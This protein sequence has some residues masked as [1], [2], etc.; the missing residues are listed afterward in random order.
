MRRGL[1]L[2]LGLVLS[3]MAG[4]AHADSTKPTLVEVWH[5]GD[6]SLS[7]GLFLTVENAFKHSPE[8]TLSSGLKTGTL[9]V[10]IPTHVEWRRVGQR[11][12]VLYKV[13]FSSTEGRNLS[14]RKGTC[15]DNEM[16]KC[17]AHIVND[18]KV[19]VHKLDQGQDGK[20][21]FGLSGAVACRPA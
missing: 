2:V 19:A 8:F 12:R 21:S 17:A 6:D 16:E 9:V 15:W 4:A 7:Q 18:A 1:Q 10:T 20:L 5:L 3:M 11:T 14:V 13:E